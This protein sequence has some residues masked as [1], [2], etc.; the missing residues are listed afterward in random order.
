MEEMYDF[1]KEKIQEMQEKKTTSVQMDFADVAKLYQ[2]I[3]FM[4]QIKNIIV[5][6]LE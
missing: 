3:C 4:N 2:I 5:D 1:L 6:G